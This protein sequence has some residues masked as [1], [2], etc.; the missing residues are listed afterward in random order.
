MRLRLTSLLRRIKI[1]LGKKSILKPV[2]TK[3]NIK[4]TS[5]TKIKSG[6]SLTKLGKK[7]PKSSK[8]NS[9]TEKPLKN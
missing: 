3:P 4:A 7:L 9:I 8:S 2:L 6:N 5:L 1:N